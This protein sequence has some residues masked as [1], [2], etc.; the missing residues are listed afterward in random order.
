LDQIDQ[1]QEQMK[2]NPNNTNGD[3]GVGR[4]NLSQS[5]VQDA[6]AGLGKAGSDKFSASTQDAMANYLINKTKLQ[7][8]QNGTVP[9]EELIDDLA[10]VFPTMPTSGGK[11]PA[12][13]DP[14][15]PVEVIK[16]ILEGIKNPE[17]ETPI[18]ETDETQAPVPINP[19]CLGI[20]RNGANVGTGTVI[21]FSGTMV[22]NAQVIGILTARIGQFVTVEI[23]ERVRIARVV[24]LN[25]AKDI[26]HIRLYD[27]KDLVPVDRAGY[28]GSA[29]LRAIGYA[30][31]QT[32]TEV[33]GTPSGQSNKTVTYKGPGNPAKGLV[34]YGLSIM[35]TLNTT[36]LQPGMAGGP[37]LNPAGQMIGIISANASGSTTAYYI[38][39]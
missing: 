1:I 23:A 12:G 3:T 34:V 37:V 38:P 13:G 31:G 30:F 22:T 27:Y 9:V 39:Y 19:L 4:Y 17:K 36:G 24:A 7:Q 14:L 18:D 2:A 29:Q 26:A 6:K 16:E 10:E 35:N 8:Y 25:P 20:V 32:I 21:D 28:T 11:T 15:V 5:Q 33:P